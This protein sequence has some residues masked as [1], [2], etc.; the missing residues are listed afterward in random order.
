MSRHQP[1]LAGVFET[2][3]MEINIGHTMKR[4]IEHAYQTSEN[5]QPGML[6]VHQWFGE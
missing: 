2:G 6:S 4:D 1:E 3:E 5:T